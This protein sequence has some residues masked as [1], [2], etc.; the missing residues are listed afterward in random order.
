[1]TRPRGRNDQRRRRTPAPDNQVCAWC[2]QRPWD[3]AVV[4]CV[5]FDIRALPRIVHVWPD[6]IGVPLDTP[7]RCGTSVGQPHHYDCDLEMCPW[8]DTH[9][10]GPEGVEQLLFC[11][12]LA[13]DEE[14]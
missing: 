7:C 10:D 4:G 11:G 8:A 2:E 5:Q 13:G 9:N 3:P 1:M 14:P 12:C 6:D